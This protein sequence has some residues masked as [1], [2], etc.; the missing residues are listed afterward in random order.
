MDTGYIPFNPILEPPTLARLSSRLVHTRSKE[1][2]ALVGKT[3]EIGFPS[4]TKFTLREGW[5]VC[6]S[7]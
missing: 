3:P 2:E 7:G 5:R 6:V 1:F 4:H